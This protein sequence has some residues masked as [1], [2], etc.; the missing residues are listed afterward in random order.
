MNPKCTVSLRRAVYLNRWQKRIDAENLEGLTHNESYRGFAAHQETLERISRGRPAKMSLTAVEL[1]RGVLIFSRSLQGQQGLQLF[2][3]YMADNFHQPTNDGLKTLK[4]YEFA[5]DRK[6]LIA[7]ADKCYHGRGFNLSREL[8]EFESA[9]SKQ[10]DLLPSSINPAVQFDMRPSIDSL[11]R[12]VTENMLGL[13][14]HN[15]DIMTLQ[16]IAEE[17]YHPMAV[18]NSFTYLKEFSKIDK[19]LKHVEDAKGLSAF[20]PYEQQYKLVQD[21]A[22][23]KAQYLLDNIVRVRKDFSDE[24]MMRKIGDNRNLSGKQKSSLTES[25][26]NEKRSGNHRSRKR[27]R[28]P[29]N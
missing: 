10:K 19:E 14:G 11:D 27:N 7:L 12:F 20:F 17:G 5:S 24:S 29:R 4:I 18:G 28:K 3:Q 6:E 9:M 22:K 1:D 21:D 26:R 23:L 2:L 15:Y 16:S 8:F 13:S 25:L